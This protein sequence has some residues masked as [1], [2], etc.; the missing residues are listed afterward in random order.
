MAAVIY[1][2]NNNNYQFPIQIIQYP[3]NNN[4]ILNLNTNHREGIFNNNINE[5]K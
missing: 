4:K 3:E 2:Q 5:K 1:S